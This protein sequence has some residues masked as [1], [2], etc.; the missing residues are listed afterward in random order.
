MWHLY[1][2]DKIYLSILP[3]KNYVAAR[4]SKP[5]FVVDVCLSRDDRLPGVDPVDEGRKR[6]SAQ[7]EPQ[8]R[9]K[10]WCGVGVWKAPFPTFLRSIV[11]YFPLYQTTADVHDGARSGVLRQVDVSAF[12]QEGGVG[13][14]E[15]EG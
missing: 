3:G 12:G 5:E 4:G 13:A 2:P 1:Y 6:A 14:I 7:E 8:R 15:V 11:W 9:T 10:P